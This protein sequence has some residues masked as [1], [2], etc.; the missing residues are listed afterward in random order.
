MHTAVSLHF[1]GRNS[2]FLMF[3]H[4]YFHLYTHVS[5]FEFQFKIKI[6]C[7]YFETNK[8][9]YF[10][11]SIK[12]KNNQSL[13]NQCKCTH[14]HTTNKYT[15]SYLCILQTKTLINNEFYK[16]KF[17]SFKLLKTKTTNLKEI[18]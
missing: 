17:Y 2:K 4:R 5:H 11:E 14:I 6:K 8:A 3:T 18:G 7:I 9:R 1:I 10:I 16:C 15:R 13:I 12:K